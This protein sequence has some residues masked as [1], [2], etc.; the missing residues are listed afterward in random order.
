MASNTSENKVPLQPLIIDQSI[1]GQSHTS[2]DDPFVVNGNGGVYSCIILDGVKYVRIEDVT[3]LVGPPILITDNESIP[4]IPKNR[5]I[6]HFSMGG[7]ILKKDKELERY[8]DDD[9]K[10]HVQGFFLTT[11][12]KEIVFE[13]N[14]RWVDNFKQ[15]HGIICINSDVQLNNIQVD[16]NREND[17]DLPYL[18]QMGKSIYCI[19]STIQIRDCTFDIDTQT[20]QLESCLFDNTTCLMHNCQVKMNKPISLENSSQLVVSDCSL[21]CDEHFIIET[22]TWA[23]RSCYAGIYGNTTLT[24]V[25]ESRDLPVQRG[26]IFLFGFGIT[27]KTYVQETCVIKNIQQWVND[28]KTDVDGDYNGRY[29]VK[30]GGGA[31]KLREAELQQACVNGRQRPMEMYNL[32]PVYAAIVLRT[33]P[34]VIVMHLSN[35]LPLD[36]IKLVLRLLDIPQDILALT[37]QKYNDFK[38]GGGSGGGGGGGGGSGGGGGGKK[39]KRGLY[40]VF[41]LKL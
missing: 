7:N 39:T 15:P 24:H 1:V 41:I 18:G 27:I 12:K 38:S 6:C 19:G 28:V 2:W 32:K 3:V 31:Y 5:W 34:M 16:T 9:G 30:G 40:K 26:D 17:T 20:N 35:T 37:G 21:K 29:V 11:N 22:N 23:D 4:D 36:V 14:G 8:D 33:N 13:I 10:E 25:S